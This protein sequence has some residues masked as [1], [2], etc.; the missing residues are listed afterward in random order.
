MAETPSWINARELAKEIQALR[1]R[2]AAL[3]EVA[4][5]YAIEL[6]A[7]KPAAAPVP[8]RKRRKRKAGKTIRGTITEILE[9]AGRPVPLDEI[10]AELKKRRIKIGGK[11]ARTS[12]SR[13]LYAGPRFKN[14]GR[15]TW[16][17][18]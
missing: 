3:E 9:S 8:A 1:T 10:L 11:D 16:T 13:S 5:Q 17:L 14:V 4:K 12:L 6:D 7:A 18:L 2:L 15:N